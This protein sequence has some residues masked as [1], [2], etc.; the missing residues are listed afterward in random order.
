MEQSINI[1]KKSTLRKSWFSWS[2]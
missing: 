1:K 2:Y